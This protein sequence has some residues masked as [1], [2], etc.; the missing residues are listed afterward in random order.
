M[1]ILSS[2]LNNIQSEWFNLYAN[3]NSSKNA[4]LFNISFKYKCE[5][6]NFFVR[7]NIY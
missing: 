1:E 3:V 2:G 5:A 6:L 7:F 4:K